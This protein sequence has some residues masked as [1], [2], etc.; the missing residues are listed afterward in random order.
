[1]MSKP[2]SLPAWGAGIEI[3]QRIR[4]ITD[5]RSLPAWGAGIEIFIKLTIILI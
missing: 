4:G 1:M 5:I 3:D 2:Q